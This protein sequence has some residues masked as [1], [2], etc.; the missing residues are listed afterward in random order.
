M[1]FLKDNKLNIFLPL[2]I[3]LVA[4]ILLTLSLSQLQLES[5]APF[6]YEIFF[7]TNRPES[8]TGLSSRQAASS[9]IETVG[10]FVMF[11]VIVVIALWIITFILRPKA[12]KRM[13]S[14]IITYFII[15]LV[16]HLMLGYVREFEFGRDLFGEALSGELEEDGSPLDT[17]PPP[18]QFI[19][20]PPQWLL[21][22]ITFGLLLGALILARYF[23][24]QRH[25]I[26]PREADTPLTL[27]AQEAQL[28][29][30]QLHQGGDFK[31]SVLGCYQAMTRILQ[32]DR[33]VQREQ[34][35]TPRDFEQHLVK[36]GFAD[37]HIHHL[38]RLF[39]KVRYGNSTPSDVEENEAISCL[40]AIVRS[41]GNVS[42]N[43]G[44]I[45]E[46]IS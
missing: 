34:G 15:L 5:G 44:L 21:F 20:E 6:P 24:Q 4:L 11:A 41:Y 18:P 33:G 28:T 19:T 36:L 46:G 3:A 14:R 23:W 8:T 16:L 26:P 9:L 43:E 29:L 37:Q 31:N 7:N 2:G 45:N 17:L 40:S 13:L 38:T 10:L 27:L 1:I 12:R 25:F 35:M 30:K 39:E 32:E 22:I 42:E